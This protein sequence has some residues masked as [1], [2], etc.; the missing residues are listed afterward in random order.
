METI[1][2]RLCFKFWLEIVVVKLRSKLV[3]QSFKI[4]VVSQL[5]LH[6]V[7][8]SIKESH[9]S[10]SQF[11]SSVCCRR[12]SV[13]LWFVFDVSVFGW[14]VI[15]RGLLGVKCSPECSAWIKHSLLQPGEHGMSFLFISVRKLVNYLHLKSDFWFVAISKHEI[16]SV[17][18]TLI[19]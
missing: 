17:I 16:F 5:F 1:A 19:R 9:W 7:L 3:S 8:S 2:V 18:A 13:G 11:L 6:V 15:V 12:L 10:Q 4:F 14:W